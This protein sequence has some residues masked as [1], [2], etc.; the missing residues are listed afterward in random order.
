MD[1]LQGLV[2]IALILGI[3]VL[4]SNN[5]R[6][7]NLRLV[8]SGIA[9]QAAIAL[10]IFKVGF[11]ARFFQM[12][13]DGIGVL[14][15]LVS[16]GTQRAPNAEVWSVQADLGVLERRR[17]GEL[18]DQYRISLVRWREGGFAAALLPQPR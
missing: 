11:I 16:R 5:R 15:T 13:G 6:K 12:L 10:L 7:I 14:V 17:G 1:R 9:L 3:A 4:A 2:G 8:G 18:A